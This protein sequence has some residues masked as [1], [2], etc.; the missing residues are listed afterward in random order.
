[1]P[2]CEME[3]QRRRK[4]G[5]EGAGCQ[6]QA[7]LTS[8]CK[9]N[10]K[11]QNKNQAALKN[12]GAYQQ[13]GRAKTEEDRNESARGRSAGSGSSLQESCGKAQRP[14]WGKRTVYPEV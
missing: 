4:S 6:A 3:Q 14:G 5:R 13:R 1:M 9:A 7:G 2:F 11:K 10:K 12:I 8:L